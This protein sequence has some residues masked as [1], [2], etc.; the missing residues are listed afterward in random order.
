[1]LASQPIEV[2]S[3]VDECEDSN[4]IVEHFIHEAVPENEDLPDVGIA[5]LGH[6]AAAKGKRTER[7]CDVECR[8][9]DLFGRLR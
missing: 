3:T 9:E 1:M 2:A 7:R 5:N 8:L 6:Y 4:L